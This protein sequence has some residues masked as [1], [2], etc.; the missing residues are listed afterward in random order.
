MRILRI[1]FKKWIGVRRWEGGEGDFGAGSAGFSRLGGLKDQ[2]MGIGGGEGLGLGGGD[3]P[4]MIE[5]PERELAVVCVQAVDHPCEKRVA[6]EGEEVS[7]PGKE[8]ELLGGI[9]FHERDRGGCGLRG[10]GWEG[11]QGAEEGAE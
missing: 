8:G 7:G 5:F 1:F 11:M 9:P 3:T 4:D 2:V 10:D 6:P